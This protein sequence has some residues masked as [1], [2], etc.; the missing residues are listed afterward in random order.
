MLVACNNST[1][2]TRFGTPFPAGD[3]NVPDEPVDG[4]DATPPDVS[5]GVTASNATPNTGD[6]VTFG[7]SATDN[8][9]GV[10]TYEWSDNGA[11]GTFT[12]EGG[13][14]TW[15]I[16]AAGVY[17][18][19][20]KVT[21][22][23]GNYAF[24]F[25]PM[26]VGGDVLPPDLG[27]G[28]SASVN[29][30][31]PGEDT[32]FTITATDD[33][34]GLTYV[35]DDNGAGGTFTGDGDSVTY[36]NDTPGTYVI[37]V[38][39]TDGAGNESASSFVIIVGGGVVNNPPTFGDED[40]EKDVS[41]PVVGQIVKFAPGD[42]A[43][44]LDGDMLSYTWDFGGDG[45][46]SNDPH[47]H[48]G[49]PSTYWTVDAAGS[50]SATL[51]ADDGNGGTAAVT[52]DFDVVVMPDISGWVGYEAGCACHTDEI[53]GWEATAHANAFENSLGP[54]GH[55]Y[56]RESCYNCHAVGIHPVGTGGFISMD[57]TPQFADIQCESCHGSGVGAGMGEGHMPEPYDPG[58][59]Y[60]VDEFG[61]YVMNEEGVYQYDEAYD[62][63]AGYGCGLCHEGSRHGAF[64]SWM[65][66]GHASFLVFEEDGVTPEHKQTGTSCA[67]CHYG[68][69]Y[70]RV[71]IRGGD[72]TEF[73]AETDF[74]A[75]NAH[76]TCGTCHDPHGNAFEGQLRWDSDGTVGIPFSDTD[77]VP[78]MVSG[79][80][81]N[82][83]ISCHDGRRDRGDY[84][85]RVTNG[86]GHFGP[87]GNP[88]G[89][90]LFG[91]MG[92]DLGNP[93]VATEYDAEHAHLTW[94]ENTCVTC[95]MYR[96]DYIDSDN[97]A[98]WGHEMEPRFE[99]CVAC[100]SN[101]T[102][103][104]E[105]WLWVEEHE[106]EVD[107]LLQAFVD[108]WPDEWKDV[109]DPAD[110]ELYNRPVVSDPPE[111]DDHEGPPKDDPIGNAY[112]AA[113]WNYYLVMNDAS[114]GIHNPTFTASLLVEGTAAVQALPAP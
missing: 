41:G 27:S 43:T 111:P 110:P 46:L 16:G 72:P 38:Y 24:A 48:E 92:G 100:H 21:D 30:P 68:P 51:T 76:I 58:T 47:P 67:Y 93:P 54:D 94:N 97:P 31:A 114:H 55:G 36:N 35:W 59:G 56:R 99:A 32:T 65:D 77:D 10:M 12:G 18:I 34:N 104:G 62:G 74:D 3:I 109:S 50:Y 66:S 44:D 60:E 13:T 102:D 64:E 7:I 81:G 69:E 86:S 90:V 80:V 105:F 79:G 28:I 26:N 101:F 20:V 108:A 106:A 91:I 85:S 78:T 61:A 75:A 14:V 11:G 42:A 1:R 83:C 70:V 88:Q 49:I 63:S 9:G 39:V 40:L 5:A 37:T 2:A 113:L 52:L 89:P 57:I 19:S 25:F 23:S 87:H 17:V 98:Q 15:S 33:G 53:T 4:D 22:A 95:H 8:S 96:S 112:R 107:V 73:D 84:D 45:T 103:E 71:K 29:D 82:I 6:I